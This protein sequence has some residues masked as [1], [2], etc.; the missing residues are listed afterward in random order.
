MPSTIMY[1]VEQYA[2]L[3]DDG[4]RAELVRG[5]LVREPQPAYGHG[6]VQAELIHRIKL[7]LEQSNL[8][9]VCVGPVGSIL[10]RNPD[11]V[12]GPDAAV[13]RGERLPPGNRVGFLDGAP[14]LAIEIVSPS[15]TAAQIREKVTDYLAAGATCVWVIDA[16]RRTAVMHSSRGVALPLGER[17]ELSCENVLPG[18][19]LKLT[20]LFDPAD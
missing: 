8:P 19:R 1:T 4:Y 5:M 9:L 3:P 11:T 6:R 20:E 16:R 12:R 17:D 15:N 14:D 13:I 7:F 10:A 18:F 2:Q